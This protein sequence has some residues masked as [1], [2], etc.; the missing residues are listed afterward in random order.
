MGVTRSVKPNLQ[1]TNYPPPSRQKRNKYN[2]QTLV[3]PR[4]YEMVKPQQ[5][6]YSSCLEA[7]PTSTRCLDQISGTQAWCT[8]TKT[9]KGEHRYLQVSIPPLQVR[10]RDE[11]TVCKQE[12]GNHQ[13]IDITGFQSSQS[14]TSIWLSSNS[15]LNLLSPHLS[16]QAQFYSPQKLTSAKIKIKIFHPKHGKIFL[17]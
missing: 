12:I 9:E 14:L 4:N 3:A 16:V 5:I 8:L 17:V 13:K 11:T 15:S 6:I 1:F 10:K 7:T 2:K